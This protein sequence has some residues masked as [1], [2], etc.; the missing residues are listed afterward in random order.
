MFKKEIF[1]D[2]RSTSKLDS[3][4]DLWQIFQNKSISRN[5]AYSFHFAKP[6]LFKTVAI[7]FLPISLWKYEAFNSHN[8]E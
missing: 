3:H 5:T 6:L 1:L 4:Y 8:D 7:L 2:Y